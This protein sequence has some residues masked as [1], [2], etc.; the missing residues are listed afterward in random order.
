M[1]DILQ[2][3]DLAKK[4]FC[5]KCL[6]IIFKIIYIRMRDEESPRDQVIEGWNKSPLTR[7]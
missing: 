4:R 3:I 1:L 5:K 7:R 6:A 2:I